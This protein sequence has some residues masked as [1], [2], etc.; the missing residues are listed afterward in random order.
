VTLWWTPQINVGRVQ[1][2]RAL[3]I[4]VDAK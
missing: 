1:H 3:M 4:T 2:A